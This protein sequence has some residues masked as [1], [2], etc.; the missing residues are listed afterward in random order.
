MFPYIIAI[1]RPD[2]KRP[3]CEI[4]TDVAENTETLFEIFNNII[5]D[6]MLE[7]SVPINRK[8]VSYSK[9]HDAFYSE[10]Y[11]HQQPIEIKYFI[12]GQWVYYSFETNEEIMN[13]Y[14]I[15]YD[16]LTAPINYDDDLDDIHNKET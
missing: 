1:A 2:W 12:D 8:F 3:H 9:F 16:E 13:L 4:K 5:V 10:Y 6:E 14:S 7:L 11:M 15:K